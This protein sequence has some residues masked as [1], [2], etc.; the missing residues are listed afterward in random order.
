MKLIDVLDIL[1]RKYHEAYKSK[2]VKKP[3]SWALYHTWQIVD[4]TETERIICDHA[5]ER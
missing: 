5:N 4:A 2:Y 1:K 3:L